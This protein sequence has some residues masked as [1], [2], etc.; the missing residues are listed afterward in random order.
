M[1]CVTLQRYASDVSSVAGP[2]AAARGISTGNR[3][4]LGLAASNALRPSAAM[5]DSR[6]NAVG[7]ML[8][9]LRDALWKRAEEVVED[10]AALACYQQ[11]LAQALQ[12]S[13]PVAEGE[14]RQLALDR[15]RAIRSQLIDKNQI[16][17]S[18]VFVLEPTADAANDR[19]QVI[20]KVSVNSD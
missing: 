14:L 8:R 12:A 19:Q 11:A 2:T 17:E 20:S 9:R 18:R 7:R 10:D 15:A 16:A 6:H 13:Q 3:S 1:S 5:A 4:R